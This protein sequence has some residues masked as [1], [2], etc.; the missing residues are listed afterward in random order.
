MPSK[1]AVETAQ[2]VLDAR[3]GHRDFTIPRARAEAL[4]RD[5]DLVKV[6]LHAAG[7]QYMPVR[8]NDGR[9]LRRI[10]GD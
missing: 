4:Y 8:K 2:I 1:I 7:F 5:G 6:H 10:R 3:D 9:I